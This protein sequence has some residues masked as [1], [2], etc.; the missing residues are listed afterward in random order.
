MR[1]HQTDADVQ[2]EGCRVLESLA[3]DAALVRKLL[4]AEVVEA[5]VTTMRSH[6]SS[7]KI[8]MLGCKMLG[9]LA[10]DAEE[11]REIVDDG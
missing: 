6:C 11:L 9:H 8:Q 2:E 5:V 7:Q 4:E 10:A 1:E 3:K